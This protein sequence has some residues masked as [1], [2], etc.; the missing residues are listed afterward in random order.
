[1]NNYCSSIQSGRSLVTD[2]NQVNVLSN[3]YQKYKYS[4]SIVLPTAL[5][6]QFSFMEV[7]LADVLQSVPEIKL[8]KN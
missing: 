7:K 3:L 4:V 5:L 6:K 2:E 8:S 1:M